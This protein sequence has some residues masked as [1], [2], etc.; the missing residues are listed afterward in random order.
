LQVIKI[1]EI[2][3]RQFMIT[4]NSNLSLKDYIK[5]NYY[6]FYKSWMGKFLTG[7]G[8][9]FIIGSFQEEFSWWHFIFGFLTAVIIPIQIYFLSKRNYHIHKQISCQKTYQINSD[10]ILINSEFANADISWKVIH[11]VKESKDWF[12]IFENQKAA[13]ILSKKDIS[14]DDLVKLREFAVS[15]KKMKI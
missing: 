15:N 9:I 11:Q 3:N 14:S 2:F 4:I 6:F 5:F 1:F 7:L 13:H 10:N 12:L 8:I